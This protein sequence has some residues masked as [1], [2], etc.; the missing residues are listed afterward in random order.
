MTLLFELIIEQDEFSYLTF[1]LKLAGR[2]EEVRNSQWYGGQNAGPN[3]LL[4][5]KFFT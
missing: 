5:C 4:L 2:S 3:I 1:A